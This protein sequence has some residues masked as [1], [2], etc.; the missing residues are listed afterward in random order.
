MYLRFLTVQ[1]FYKLSLKTHMETNQEINRY[2]ANAKEILRTKAQKDGNEYKDIK[3]VQMASGTAYNA[4]LMIADE[5]L[6]KKEGNKFIKPKA[7]KTIATGLE[8]TIRHYYR[9]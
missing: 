8:S 5:Y 9:I 3:Y 2:L 4:A 6:L 7:L 1:D